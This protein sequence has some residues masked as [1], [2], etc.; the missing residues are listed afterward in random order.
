MTDVE[1]CLTLTIPDTR[2]LVLEKV[3]AFCQEMERQGIAFTVDGPSSPDLD[4]RLDEIEANV[5]AVP[6]SEEDRRDFRERIADQRS[7]NRVLRS[8]GR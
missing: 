4:R 1:I 7:L 5:A 6:M 8:I 2:P 3:M